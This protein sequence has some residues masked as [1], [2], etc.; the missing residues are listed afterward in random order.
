MRRVLVVIIWSLVALAGLA[1][2]DSIPIG[3]LS[4]LGTTPDGSSIFNAS[5]GVVPVKFT[6]ARNGAATCQLPPA[7][8]SVTRIAGGTTG[9]VDESVYLQN[10]D[11]GSN[12]R[13]SGCQYA[14]NLQSSALGIGTYRVDISISGKVVGSAV[15]ALK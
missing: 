1:R 13:I 9:L 4:Y 2:A 12:F 15:F 11:T 7:T 6:L 10:A 14:Y 5:R 8:I 3:Q